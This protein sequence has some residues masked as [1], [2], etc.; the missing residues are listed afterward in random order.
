LP[1]RNLGS[2]RT[3][4]SLSEPVELDFRW[5]IDGFLRAWEAGAFGDDR[6][7]LV[8]GRLLNVVIGDWHGAVVMQVGALLRSDGV[9]VTASS[10]MTGD[11]VPDP[12]CWV[13]RA[14][15]QASAVV[16][17]LSRWRP[18]DVLLVVEVSDDSKDL[19][20]GEKADLYA[21]G[22]F[23]TYWVIHR[24]GVEVFTHPHEGTYR[25]RRSLV[26]GD[27]VVT[28]YGP[29]SGLAVDDLISG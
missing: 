1:G 24:D 25:D 4:D 5:G 10:L 11:S 29:A 16:G 20:L 15:A 27:R 18:E 2:V 22:G 17:R 6:V 3:A 26:A 13:R 23:E 14:G 8:N 21:A 9:K 12:D 19:D 28:P 7:E